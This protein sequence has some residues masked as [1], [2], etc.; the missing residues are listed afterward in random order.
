VKLSACQ[1]EAVSGSIRHRD[2]RDIKDLNA[3]DP[4]DYYAIIERDHQIQNP[5]SAAKL[6]QL[7]DYLT[8]EDGHRI[9]DV[10]CGKAGLLRAIARKK[11]VQA[12]GLE[13]NAVFA[14]EARTAIEQAGLQGNID[15]R[16]GPALSYEDRS[17]AFDVTLCIGASFAIGSFEAA[18]GWLNART[19][20]GGRLAIGEPYALRKPFPAAYREEHASFE[21]SLSET[22][23]ILEATNLELTGL[24]AAEPDDW[25]HYESQRWNAA[26]LWAKSNATHR[27]RAAV[28]ERIKR[29]RREHLEFVRNYLGWAIFVCRTKSR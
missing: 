20:P 3:V 11:T 29:E 1:P 15:I 18:L 19:K 5:T 4:R 24:I 27:D 21:R 16:Q 25:D 2:D 10:G 22:A 8:I 28:L 6:S 17:T 23:D 12:L 13:V 26:Q 14:A 9:L 7:V